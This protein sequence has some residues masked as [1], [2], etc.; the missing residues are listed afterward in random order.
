MARLKRASIIG[1]FGG[2]G[3]G[4][5]HKCIEL[6]KR[7]RRLIVW[8]SQEE[9]AERANCVRVEN[10]LKAIIPMM[11]KKQWRIAFIPSFDAINVQFGYFCKIVRAIG[12]CRCVVE[13]LNEVTS[14]SFAPPEWKWLT[15]RGRHR[16]LKII[17]MAQRPASVDK[18]FIGN[19][20]EIYSGRLNYEGD[21]TAL[22]SKF[23]RK[24][25]AELSNLPDWTLK[26]WP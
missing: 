1:L 15:S 21:C 5:T 26:H 6:V 11:R 17:G 7:D 22:A 16:G 23:G 12:N 19:A 20:T 14:A 2:S 8:D 24:G 10:D 25:A 9:F 13:E 3:T 18:D 4:K